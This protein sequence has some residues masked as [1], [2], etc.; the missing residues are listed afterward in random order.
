MNVIF[1]FVVATVIYY[2]GLP[3][4]VNPPI[5][6]YVDP[7]SPEGKMGIQEG[8]RIVAVDGKPVKSWDEVTETTILALTN[9][10]PVTIAR[11]KTHTTNVYMLTAEANNEMHAKLLN[12]N[13][14]EHLV[15]R[16]VA[17]GSAADRRR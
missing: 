10:L 12:L 3:V 4:Q 11:E 15:V 9:V 14:L 8:D 13:S 5:I 17:K 7:Q 16:D 6:G 2:V 1:A